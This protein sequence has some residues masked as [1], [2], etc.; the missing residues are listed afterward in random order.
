[1][2]REKAVTLDEAKVILKDFILPDGG[3]AGST[4]FLSWTPGD[5]V[6]Y[7]DDKFTAEEIEAIATIMRGAPSPV[8]VSVKRWY[9]ADGTGYWNPH[10]LVVL[11]SEYDKVCAALTASEAKVKELEEAIEMLT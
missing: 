2:C 9:A 6:A 1:M 5:A 10:V 4:R 3:M 11:A 8:D 7:I